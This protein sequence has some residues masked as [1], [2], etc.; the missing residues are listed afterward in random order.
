MV[1]DRILTFLKSLHLDV[2]LPKGIHVMNPYKDPY[3]L[4]LCEKFYRKYY[5]DENLRTLIVGINPGRFGSGTTGISF[6]DPIKLEIRCGITNTL[7]KKPELSADFIYMMI[8]AF[9]GTEEFY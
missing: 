7:P 2:R 6:T 1:A 5:D 4:S 9:G 8:E 3:T